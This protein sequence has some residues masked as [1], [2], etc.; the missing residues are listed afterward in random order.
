M[1][2]SANMV[3]STHEASNESPGCTPTQTLSG[4]STVSV[5]WE[6]DETERG[7]ILTLSAR[8]LYRT[9]FTPAAQSRPAGRLDDGRTG[10]PCALVPHC[11]WW[12][13]K[14]YGLSSVPANKPPPNLRF[15]LQWWSFK[16]RQ[17]AS[18]YW[19]NDKLLL[20]CAKTLPLDTEILI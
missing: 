16:R 8:C 3:I 9:A 15:G 19:K 5:A 7:D 6:V 17:V 13:V 10:R 11:V 12:E 18:V 1:W 4:L 20:R 2:I 14:A